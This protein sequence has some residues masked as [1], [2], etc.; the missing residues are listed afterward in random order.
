MTQVAVVGATGQVG[1]ALTEAL[2]GRGVGVRAIARGAARLET[3][4][5]Q[6]AEPYAGSADDPKFLAQAFRGVDAAF[7]MIPPDYRH[8]DPLARARQVADAQAAAVQ[9]ARVKHV[10]L[11]SSLGA[12]QAEG[13]GLIAG[14][15]YF[16]GRLGR[17][18]GLHL[19]A[20]R[21]AYFMENLLGNIGL[22]RSAGFNGSGFRPE[23]SLP[24]VATRDIAEVAAG[25]LADLGWTG[26]ATRELHGPQDVT[27]PEVTLALGQA[28]GKPDL[29]YVPFP[30][31]EVREALRAAGFSPTSA[32]LMVEM[33][34][35]FNTG[36]VGAREP[37]SPRT[38]TPTTIEEFARTV[39]APAYGA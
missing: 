6:G 12:E 34:D 10:V 9:V 35:G 19:L 5:A 38:T 33:I 3:L 39:F 13:N 20:L 30:Y 22:I 8:P 27:F 2:R 29:G 37:R 11:L 31:P 28:I 7:L 36:R 25:A 26:Q 24:M 1:R 15:H 23:T 4:A 14:L 18:P 17:I 16:E 32:D 21:P